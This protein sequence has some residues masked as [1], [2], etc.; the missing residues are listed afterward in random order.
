MLIFTVTQPADLH[1]AVA[2][3]PSHYHPPSRMIMTC[4]EQFML[5]HSYPNGA[6]SY[7]FLSHIWQHLSGYLLHDLWDF[8]QA[9]SR[10]TVPRLSSRPEKRGVQVCPS[11]HTPHWT[12]H[13]LSWFLLGF[14]LTCQKHEHWSPNLSMYL[15]PYNISHQEAAGSWTLPVSNDFISIK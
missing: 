3:E 8:L 2:P 9:I 15:D 6:D 7:I 4:S 1:S 14:Q 10:I 12:E 5:G 11:R 13:Q